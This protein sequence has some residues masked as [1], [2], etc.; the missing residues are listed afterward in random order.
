MIN[1]IE[2][3]LLDLDGTLIQFNLNLFIQEY[4]RQIQRH[5]SHYSFA[6]FVPDWI[7]KGTERMLSN[8][9]TMTNKQV[10][11]NYFQQ[12][13]GLS[14]EEM[15][16]IFL[17]FYKSDY[18]HLKDITEPVKGARVFLE[19]AKSQGYRLVIATQP[20]FPEIAIQKRLLWAGVGHLS[21]DLI[22]NI[23]NMHACKPHRYY[24]QQILDLLD[25][26]H[27]KCLMIG[28]DAEMDLAAGKI[29]IKTYFLN[30][31][32]VNIV[33]SKAHYQGDF[34]NLAQLLELKHPS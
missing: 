25:T 12:K 30:T 7:L 5:F 32:A 13:S 15:W 9:G 34:R 6:K 2:Y 31:D 20:V 22:T 1:E 10:F 17:H 33:N 14:E 19:A 27:D 18:N 29:G 24:F 26:Q 16:E 8:K 11:L 4:L 23:E 3:L 28:N 21:Y